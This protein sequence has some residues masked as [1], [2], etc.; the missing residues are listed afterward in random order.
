M[1]NVMRVPLW[2]LVLALLVA[3]A[4][5]EW[6]ARRADELS[7]ADANM[8]RVLRASRAHRDSLAV[9]EHAEQ[10]HVQRAARAEHGAAVALKTA[11]SLQRVADSLHEAMKPP[12][13]PL[14]LHTVPN[15]EVDALRLEIGALRGAV[16]SQGVA[17]AH[18]DGAYRAASLRAA[19]AENRVVSLESAGRAVIKADACR[20]FSLPPCIRGVTVGASAGYGGTASGGT[21]HLGPSVLVGLQV[22]L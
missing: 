16:D 14:G 12:E 21:L 11:D 13:T 2:G 22:Q 8:V 19:I 18:L 20:L 4:W 6:G 7:A 10:A 15:P 9:L 17:L 1:P 3:L 5:M